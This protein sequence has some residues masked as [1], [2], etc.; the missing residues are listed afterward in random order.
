MFKK[1][2]QQ[3]QLNDN[4]TIEEMLSR[5]NE[6]DDFERME[7]RS[8]TKPLFISF[9]DPMVDM[10]SMQEYVITPL[11][12]R[13][14]TSKEDIIKTIWNI[15][16]TWSTNT[17]EVY[18]NLG[19]GHVF[20]QL[21]R[22]ANE[23]LLIDVKNVIKREVTMPEIEFSVTGPQEAFVETLSDN[24][25]LLRKRIPH[26]NLIVKDKV[27]GTESNTKFAILY[28][29]GLADEVNVNTVMQRI[30]EIDFDH[31]QDATT[32]AQMIED[33]TFTI[34]PQFINTERPDRA[35]SVLVE[36]KVVILA[37]GS[38]EA[39]TL[40][41]TLMQFFSSLEDYYLPWSM[42]SF[43]RLLRFFAVGFSVLATS[44]YVAVTTYHYEM[45]PE[46]LLATLV[47]SRSNIPFPP[48]VEALFLEFTIEL[49][50][51]AAARLP[52]KIGQTIG[53]VGGIV[54]GQASVEAGLTSNVLLIIVALAA[55]ASFT[56]PVYQMGNTIRIIRFP[57]LISAAVLGAIGI[58]IVFMFLLVHLLKLTSLGRPYLEPIYPFRITDWRDAFVRFPFQYLNKRPAFARAQKRA[59]FPKT[60]SK[61]YKDKDI[62]E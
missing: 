45:I 50:R 62:D 22:R 13:K 28:I 48:I 12:L 5:L 36:G 55:L 57:F 53:I 7:I 14:V 60:K 32:V 49:L 52:T 19:R 9:F 25:H 61:Q 18:E 31:I 3:H 10:A 26:S 58:A 34:F 47:S 27:V 41:S 56:T 8:D 39:I 35:A 17:N 21:E 30:E 1:R 42:A 51:E 40:P 15:E 16:A 46:D 33:H 24:I 20:I 23:G 54:I 29:D 4:E 44:I 43:V 6:S 59:R 2:Y 11:K 38:P 37:E